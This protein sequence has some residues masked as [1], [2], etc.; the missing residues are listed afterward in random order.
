MAIIN[1]ERFMRILTRKFICII[2]AVAALVSCKQDDTLQY[3]NVT[4][5]NVVNGTFT[6][7]Q[8]NIFN[9][10]EKNCT[11]NLESM[12][13]AII[14][15]DVLKKVEGTDNVYDIRLNHMAEVPTK[16]HVN[17]TT[18]DADPVLS[19]EDPITFSNIWISGGYLNLYAVFETKSLGS[20]QKHH[21]NLVLDEKESSAGKY[22]FILR[23]NSS[24]E[25]FIHEATGIALVSDYAMSFPI[26]DLIKENSAEIT[27][28]SKWY[29]NV[30]DAWSKETQE[31]SFKIS[32]TKGG[33]EHAP[34]SYRNNISERLN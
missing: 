12:D 19:V 27:V 4:M 20:I 15:C 25:S 11:G 32:Y 3:N 1:T 26:T 30:G 21:I 10:V 9:V 24:G 17:K 8:G 2:A 28:K 16:A 13:R 6:S 33:F 22:V 7:D 18:A 31:N 23:H 14:I 29:K 5:G 34:A